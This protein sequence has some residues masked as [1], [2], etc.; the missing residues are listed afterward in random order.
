MIHLL[1]YFYYTLAHKTNLES[2]DDALYSA[3][4]TVARVHAPPTAP[5]GTL[6]L[7]NDDKE[8][9]RGDTRRAKANGVQF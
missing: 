4:K 8:R 2:E 9:T 7:E 6:S 1:P 3:H 5:S